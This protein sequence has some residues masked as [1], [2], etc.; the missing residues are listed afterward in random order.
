MDN[1]SPMTTAQVGD[2][3]SLNAMKELL[4][5]DLSEAAQEEKETSLSDDLSD[6]PEVKEEPKEE[7]TESVEKDEATEA[8][9]EIKEEL[10]EEKAEGEKE[11]VKV[12]EEPGEVKFKPKNFELK[13]GDEKFTVPNNAVI[14]I[15]VD[16]GVKRVHFQEVI[17]RASG[18]ISVQ[19]RITQI[20]K[21]RQES[22]RI[23][24]EKEQLFKKK[25]TEYQKRD[26]VLKTVADLATNGKPADLLAYCARVSGKDPV[27][28][29]DKFMEDCVKWADGFKSMSDKEHEVWK[30]NLRIAVKRQDLEEK[31]KSL[32]QEEEERKARE[33]EASL[34][35]FA[36]EQLDKAS[37]SQDEF[38]SM[39]QNL[40]KQG[41]QL[42][43]P[44]DDDKAKFLEVLDYVHESR[45]FAAAK[46]VDSEL[47]KDQELLQTIY[48]VTKVRNI[49]KMDSIKGIVKGMAEERKK[50]EASRIAET[51]SRKEPKATT[52][53][54]S[55]ADENEDKAIYT[56]RDYYKRRF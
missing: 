38:N 28:T 16:G 34:H 3:I 47:L 24:Q 29:I 14:E 22:R 32:K 46:E 17:N 42:N 7:I 52:K 55:K 1:T 36:I 21:E 25:E 50:K 51:L 2:N 9:E 23:H 6:K 31:E 37:V 48:D 56:L 40:S 30:E 15:P 35:S 11:E 53:Q 13:L 12:L 20:E 26:E 8:L 33:H 18:D 49:R 27:D 10:D 54:T 43:A 5:A 45:I 41:V 4:S 19:E 44:E 39:V